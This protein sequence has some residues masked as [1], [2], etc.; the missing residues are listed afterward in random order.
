MAEINVDELGPVDYLVISFP[1]DA[2]QFSGEMA[3]EL[4]ALIDKNA[5]RV[6]DLVVLTKDADGSVDATELRD[7]DHSELGELRKLEAD[8]AILL[9]EEDILRIA[10]DLEPASAAA[11]LVYENTWAA[12]FASAI[13][14]SG[15]EVVTGGRIPTQSLIAAVEADREAADKE[16]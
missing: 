8:I 15:G 12:P 9:A 2:A 6:L 16:A 14:R 7:S 13:R 1:A 10:D 3:T 5:I 4:R 11:V